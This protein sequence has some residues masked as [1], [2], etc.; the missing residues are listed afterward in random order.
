MKKLTRIEEQILL[1]IHHLGDNAYLITIRNKVLEFTGKKYSVGTI[2]VPLNR[3]DSN[4]MVSSLTPDKDPGSSGKPI[5]YYKLT[6]NGYKALA[7]LKRVQDIMWENFTAP[8]LKE[9]ES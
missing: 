7:D 6:N 5:K 2:Y 4:E 3:M 1:A 9:E 8:Q